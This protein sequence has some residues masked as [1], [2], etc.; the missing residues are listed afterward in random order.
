MQWWAR[1]TVAGKN[2]HA[3]DEPSSTPSGV[4]Q[5]TLINDQ[6]NVSSKMVSLGFGPLRRKQR[7]GEGGRGFN[8]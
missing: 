7:G 4:I 5:I 8:Q 1:A 2:L 6:K 3:M